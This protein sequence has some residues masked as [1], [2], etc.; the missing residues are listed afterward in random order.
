ME[1]RNVHDWQNEIIVAHDCSET[2][3]SVNVWL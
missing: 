3:W 1:D 2:A